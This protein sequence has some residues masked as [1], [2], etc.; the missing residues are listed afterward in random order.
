[1]SIAGRPPPPRASYAMVVLGNDGGGARAPTRRGGSATKKEAYYANARSAHSSAAAA[2]FPAVCVF[3]GGRGV[4]VFGAQEP[5][6]R[7]NKEKSARL[8]VE[9][10][11]E[12]PTKKRRRP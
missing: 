3:G 1:M 2:G 10:G 12:T 4:R 9:M 8:A 11:H 6:V 5:R 7:G